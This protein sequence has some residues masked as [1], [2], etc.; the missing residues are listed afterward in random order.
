M[1][2]KREKGYWLKKTER[3]SSGAAAKARAG[4]LRASEHVAHVVVDQQNEEYVVS[5][6]VA[7]WYVEE[8]KKAGITL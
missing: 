3:F 4:Q 6:S 8:M 5:Y 2:R 1:R 7:K